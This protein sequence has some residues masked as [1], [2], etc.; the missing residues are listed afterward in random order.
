M[1][2]TVDASEVW[3]RFNAMRAAGED[4]SPAL[5]AIGEALAESTKRRFETSTSPDGQR[6]AENSDVTLF[7][8]LARFSKSF[9]SDGGLTQKGAARLGAKKPLIGESKSLSTMI[10]WQLVARDA[11]AIGSPM[12][13]AGVQQF[14]AEKGEFGRTK[15][16]APIPWGNI[17]ARPFVGV[18]RD[19]DETIADIVRDYLRRATE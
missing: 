12:E 11:V 5:M 3:A 18:S 1:A 10:V 7:R 13:Y 6:W 8:Y 15:R 17:P 16:G 2:L 19:D 9:R 14:G 4:L